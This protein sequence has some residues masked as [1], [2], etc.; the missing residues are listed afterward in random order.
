[1]TP[2]NK[3]SGN[4]SENY[5]ESSIKQFKYYQQLAEKSFAILSEEDW[6]YQPDKNSNSIAII[7]KHI[8][9]N[10]RSRWTDFLTSDG[11]KPWRNRD[12]EFEVD[13]SVKELKDQWC[14]AWQIL[15]KQLADLTADD[16]NQIIYIRNVGHTVTE[17]IHRQLCHYAYHIGQIVYLSKL[18]KKDTWVSLSVPKGESEKYNQKKFNQVKH[19]GH[20]TDD[21]IK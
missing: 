6:H 7:V 8:T 13:L 3:T 10:L 18:I 12:T 16:L 20:F 9:G 21:L 4:L 2:I 11:E 15:Y 1:M 5:L 14:Q 19:R 17:A